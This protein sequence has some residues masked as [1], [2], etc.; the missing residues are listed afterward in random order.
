MQENEMAAV[1]LVNEHDLAPELD[2]SIRQLLVTC[3]PKDAQFFSHSRAWH[4]SPPSFSAVVIEAEELIAH[5]GVVQRRITIGGAP[6]RVAG[7]QNVAVLPDRR[8]QGLTRKMLAAA[9]D[10]ALERGLDYGLLFCEPKTVPV[11]ARCGWL[12]LP[13]QPVVRVDSDGLEK[14]LLP[15]NLS[16]WLPL[17]KQAFPA[18]TVHLGG[19]DW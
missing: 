5:L 1:Q 13:D 8:G 4:G 6:A 17:A 18:G 14:P 9:M 11:Y 2:A 3:V 15:G 7:V 12:E 16:M 10:E 19:N